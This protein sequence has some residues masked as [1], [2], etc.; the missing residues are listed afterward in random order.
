[1]RVFRGSGLWLGLALLAGCG[2]SAA[3]VDTGV[4]AAPHPSAVVTSAPPSAMASASA[5]PAEP[6]RWASKQTL[7]APDGRAG[8]SFGASVALRGDTLVVGAPLRDDTYRDS[9]AVYVFVRKDGEYRFEQRLTG[10]DSAPADQFGAGVAVDGD[11]ILV[12]APN[13]A[14]NGAY[15]GATYVFVRHEGA[16]RFRQ[17]LLSRGIGKFFGSTIALRGDTVVVGAAGDYAEQGSAHVFVRQAGGFRLDQVL[18][19]KAIPLGREGDFLNFGYAVALEGD[20]LLVGA[21][22]HADT[23]TPPGLVFAFFRRGERWVEGQ[24]VA[25]SDS[26]MDDGFGQTI[27]VAGRTMIVGGNRAAYAFERGEAGWIE[28]QRLAADGATRVAL[29]AG[30]EVAVARGGYLWTRRE[31]AFQ[32]ALRPDPAK[33]S[34]QQIGDVVTADEETIV[35]GVPEGSG[36]GAAYVLGPEGR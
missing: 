21:H 17:K 35:V 5:V 16:Y 11:T 13:H 19:P 25:A 30:G 29:A 18:V 26:K 7:V 4:D 27:A 33:G 10:P 20:A 28:R 2:K 22:Y 3:P 8:D 34:S 36:K 1:M 32:V 15:A 23:R 24:L 12:G 31:G 6:R 9:G 14:K